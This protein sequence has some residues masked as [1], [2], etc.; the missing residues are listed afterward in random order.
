MQQAKSCSACLNNFVPYKCH[1]NSRKAH[2][3]YHH[4]HHNYNSLT[5]EDQGS[6]EDVEV[7]SVDQAEP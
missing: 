7:D 3:L 6:T 1:N 2:C 4:H 5:Q